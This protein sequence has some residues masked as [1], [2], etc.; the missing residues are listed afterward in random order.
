M[1]QPDLLTQLRLAK[2]VIQAAAMEYGLSIG[3]SIGLGGIVS[4]EGQDVR[5]YPRSDS[6]DEGPEHR[7]SFWICH[8]FAK[9]ASL[10]S[11][12]LI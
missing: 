5:S 8:A 9:T 4:D 6:H 1:S 10:H 11:S 2:A 12:P 3:L 7:N